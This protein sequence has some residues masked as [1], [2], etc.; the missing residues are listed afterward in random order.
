MSI[1]RIIREINQLPI[2][3]DPY[4]TPCLSCRYTGDIHA[5]YCEI[6]RGFEVDPFDWDME[7]EYDF[8]DDSTDMNTRGGN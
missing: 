7:G 1:G 3:L 5:E 8:D 6:V 4:Y 2:A